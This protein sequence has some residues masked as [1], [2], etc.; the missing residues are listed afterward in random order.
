MNES[1]LKGFGPEQLKVIRNE[2]VNLRKSL[3]NQDQ[4]LLDALSGFSMLP[5]SRLLDAYRSA[6]QAAKRLPNA[7]IVEFGVYRG[8]ALAAMAYGAS[9][10]GTFCGSVI[11]F[12][13]FEG[14]TCAPL[15]HETDLHGNLQRPIFDQKRSKQES[16][17]SCDLDSVLSNFNSIAHAI[18]ASLTT[19][20]LIK[21]DASST[22][23]QLPSLCPN[24]ISLLRLDMDWYKPTMASLCAATPLLCNNAVIIADDYGH[25][26]GVK[27][28]IDQ[29]LC[30]LDKK[31]DYT[32]TDYSCMRIILLD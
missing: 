31:Y 30:S 15:P 5:P 7:A 10:R 3:S 26:S 19:P 23:S 25:H 28:S 18:Q 32:M 1:D 11:G 9:L 27:E 2:L 13:T 17:A 24:G 21:G 4:K 20:V 16:W 8:G 14:H 12:D 22:A 29:W 6:E